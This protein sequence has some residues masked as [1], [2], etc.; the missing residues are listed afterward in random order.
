MR[1][2]LAELYT[3]AQLRRYLM[4]RHEATIAAGDARARK[5]SILKLLFGDEARRS[6]SLAGELLGPALSPTPASGARSPGP[7]GSP[8]RR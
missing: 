3:D 7:D 1:Q 4:L 2:R 8:G 5:G 6:A